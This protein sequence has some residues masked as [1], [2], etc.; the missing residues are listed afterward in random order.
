MS[1]YSNLIVVQDIEN[2]LPVKICRACRGTG[3]KDEYEEIMCGNCEG[4]GE[5]PA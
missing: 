3:W 4:E 1:K 5:I 2:E